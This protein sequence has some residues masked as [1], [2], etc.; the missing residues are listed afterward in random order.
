MFDLSCQVNILSTQYIGP[1]SKICQCVQFLNLSLSCLQSGPLTC[2]QIHQC[3]VWYCP[4]VSDVGS[5]ICRDPPSHSQH[6]SG[7]LGSFCSR[8]QL[9]P[10]RC[11]GTEEKHKN[12][13]NEILFP[14]TLS[15]TI[16]EPCPFPSTLCPPQSPSGNTLLSTVIKSSFVLSPLCNIISF[17]GKPA[18]M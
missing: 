11:S 16:Q 3:V 7:H 10:A 18:D 5:C 15:E 9:Q 4:D 1:T 6:E 8:L 13:V 12:R 14:E 17:F 2:T